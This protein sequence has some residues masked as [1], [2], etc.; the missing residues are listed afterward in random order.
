MTSESRKS[1]EAREA[2]AVPEPHLAVAAPSKPRIAK[3]FI[4][5]VGGLM[6]VTVVMTRLLRRRR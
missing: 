5:V 1:R 2:R 3:R 6:V 4:P